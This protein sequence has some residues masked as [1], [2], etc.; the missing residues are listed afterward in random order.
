MYMP[1]NPDLQ[2]ERMM[3]YEISVGQTFLDGQLNAEVTA[4]LIDGKDMIR[5][6]Q[7]DGRPL[8]VNTGSFINKGI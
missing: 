4:F 1:A 3:N 6:A 7:V 5:V 8:K 2:P